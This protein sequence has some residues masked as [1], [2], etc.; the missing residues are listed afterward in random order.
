M[1]NTRML[2]KNSRRSYSDRFIPR[3]SKTN[4]DL[5]FYYIEEPDDNLNKIDKC[6][7]NEW[8]TNTAEYCYNLEQYRSELCKAM[9]PDDKRILVFSSLNQD[10]KLWPVHSRSKPLLG[11]PSL[12]LDMPTLSTR[13]SDHAV[14]WGKKGYI[15]TV[16]Q[17][18]VHLWHPQETLDRHVTDT[19]KRVQN[20][21]KWNKDGTQI[22]MA[23]TMGG[24]AIW[25]CEAR[26]IIRQ[27]KCPCK[28]CRITAIEWTSSNHLIT[29]CSEG[30]LR[31]WS[32]DLVCYKSVF[33]A[34]VGAIIAIKFSCN[35]NYM[36]SSGSYSRDRV[37]RIWKWPSLQG[38][39]EISYTGKP[40]KAIAWHPWKESLLAIGGPTGISLWNV[41]LVK[42]VEHK[43]YIYEHCFVDA[44]TFN[45]LSG[46]L[47]VSYYAAVGKSVGY[48]AYVHLLSIMNNLEQRLQ[49]RTRI[50]ASGIFFG[51]TT[52][53]NTRFLK[54]AEK[55]ELSCDLFKSLNNFKHRPIR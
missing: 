29:G 1:I 53:T 6:L 55:K 48:N 9:L 15:G 18:E 23:L 22:A 2:T 16:Y 13:I 8:F 20:C 21:I 3:R 34:H 39:S 26:K 47:V 52:E 11:P 30:E 5:S 27:D 4:F 10:K 38:F 7:D 32:P 19:S 24:I 14:D 41:S 12:V 31:A 40:I 45:P 33:L 42:L 37:L 43:A 51:T 54:L 36:V 25:D 28:S 49:V 17:N 50:Y 46:E 35:E 44:L